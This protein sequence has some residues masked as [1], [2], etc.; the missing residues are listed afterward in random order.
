MQ[1]MRDTLTETFSDLE[2][3]ENSVENSAVEKPVP[4]MQQFSDNSAPIALA[5]LTQ[6]QLQLSPILESIL[7]LQEADGSWDLQEKLF[8]LLGISRE[9]IVSNAP[10]SKVK[11]CFFCIDLE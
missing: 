8:E 7:V 3:V 4:G 10:S 5:P 11:I 9:K 1:N 2:A 6:L